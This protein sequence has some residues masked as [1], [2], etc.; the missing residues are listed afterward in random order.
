MYVNVT[1]Y[2][3]KLSTT[4]TMVFSSK[5]EQTEFFNGLTK[6]DLGQCSFN[7]KR[8]IRINGNY[9]MLNIGGYNYIKIY[10]T[11]GSGNER[12]YYAFI[13]LFRYVND[14][15]CEVDVTTDYIQTYMFD[16]QFSQLFIEQR[17]YSL[18]NKNLGGVYKY[19]N[20]YPIQSYIEKLSETISGDSEIEP[21][22]PVIICVLAN[23]S[24]G[25]LS[26]AGKIIYPYN[27]IFQTPQDPSSLSTNSAVSCFIWYGT[28]TSTGSN[29]RL[30]AI[31]IEPI[32]KDQIS[33][34]EFLNKYSQYIID[35]NIS[36]TLGITNMGKDDA[37]EMWFGYFHRSLISAGEK[38]AVY[39]DWFPG[40]G[41]YVT[42][43]EELSYT[44]TIPEDI[45]RSLAISPYYNCFIKRNGDQGNLVNLANMDYDTTLKL[46]LFP[47]IFPNYET[48]IIIEEN[49]DKT[50]VFSVGAI[51]N[52]IVFNVD[53]WSEYKLTKSASVGDSLA[54]KHAYDMEIANR[55]YK[56]AKNI[57]ATNM[58]IGITNTLGSAV[59]SFGKGAA[60]GNKGGLIGGGISAL[61]NLVTG[62]VNTGLA[63]EQELENASVAY[64]NTKTTIEQESALL[65]IGYDDIKNSPDTVKN[66]GANGFNDFA[67][68][69]E[70]KF[71]IYEA[72]NI[73][74]IIKYHKRFGFET[75][76][77]TEI[78][79]LVGLH[80]T[81]AQDFDYI[82]TLN[83]AVISENI[84]R[85]SAEMIQ[86][87]FNSGI[88]LWR[89]YEKLGEDYLSNYEGE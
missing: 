13:D 2:K 86:K 54:T 20:I 87:I 36:D 58:G 59:T 78:T 83:C 89:N 52:N 85:T 33:I 60:S 63:Y 80:D 71:S 48:M 23:T 24:T 26:G 88:Y 39:I 79:D 62:S 7:G 12:T 49:K 61:S 64:E 40:G 4:D 10:Y 3:T 19:K 21:G 18:L 34:Y 11:D 31:H 35:I 37:D 69:K 6:L 51:S 68:S 66:L 1:L 46:V 14:N 73:E 30:P 22:I 55:N 43:Q 8:T 45:K 50:E 27:R 44:V 9:F 75:A 53:A 42:S 16:I 15:C 57:A 28:T 77:Q 67:L 70:L 38:T 5:E 84:P 56:N 25:E 74:E 29:Y 72:S 82:R 81:N 41:E 76:L 47:N 65:Q 17:N 32:V